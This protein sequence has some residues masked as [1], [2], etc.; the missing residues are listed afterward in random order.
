MI[1]R[2][3]RPDACSFDMSQ[4]GKLHLQMQDS[5]Y[6]DSEHIPDWLCT[7]TCLCLNCVAMLCVAMCCLVYGW[8]GEGVFLCGLSLTALSICCWLILILVLDRTHTHTHTCFPTSDLDAYEEQRTPVPAVSDDRVVLV[9]LN[10]EA[11]TCPV[12]LDLFNH[13][14]SNIEVGHH[15]A[16]V[17]VVLVWLCRPLV[18]WSERL[19]YAHWRVSMVARWLCSLFL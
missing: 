13:T 18:C 15:N 14:Q 1:P 4:N 8:P 10:F 6:F 16:V 7:R 12:C 11:L 5:R 17:I 2:R 3:R 9:K 19:S